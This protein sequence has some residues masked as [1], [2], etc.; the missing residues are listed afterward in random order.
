[1][2]NSDFLMKS[3]LILDIF[4]KTKKDMVKS[5]EQGKRMEERKKGERVR[6]S[7]KS[8]CK[9]FVGGIK[10][11]TKEAELKE[12]F[13]VC[14]SVTNCWV[15]KNPGGFGF[16]EMGSEKEAEDAAKA[17]NGTKLLGR[18]VHVALSG[19]RRT[20]W[21]QKKLKSKEAKK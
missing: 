5:V 14:G 17:L 4:I 2:S 16:V 10:S 13:S 1:M 12:A 8:E 21:C 11:S 19:K 15:A 3:Q 6:K 18:Q 20:A 7:W 9:L